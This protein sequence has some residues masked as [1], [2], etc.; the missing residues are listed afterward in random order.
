M[1]LVNTVWNSIQ[2]INVDV[3]LDLMYSDEYDGP[4][5]KVVEQACL[6]DNQTMNTIPAITQ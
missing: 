5:G 6:G 3:L 2:K 1:K 4:E